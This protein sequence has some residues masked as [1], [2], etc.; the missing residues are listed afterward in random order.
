MIKDT[1][2]NIVKSLR[3][4]KAVQITLVLLM[5]VAFVVIMINFDLPEAKDFIRAHR[6][7]AA[8][9][10]VGIYFLLGFT[11]IPSSPLTLFLAVFLGPL[12]TVAVATVGNTLAAML[13]YQ[14]GVTVGDIF[15]FEARMDDLP[16]RLGELPITSPCY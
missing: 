16:F 9:I 15:N 2:V 7:Q 1:I 12:E 14:I 8:L 13:E 11:F 4:N 5:A 6:R 10:S 3:H